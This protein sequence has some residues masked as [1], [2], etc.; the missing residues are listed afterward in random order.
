MY[1]AHCSC[2]LQGTKLA[3]D[4]AYPGTPLKHLATDNVY[5]GTSIKHLDKTTPTGTDS[6]SKGLYGL[7]YAVLQIGRTLVRLQ[8]V[9][10]EFFTDIILP[11]A[12]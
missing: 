2:C 10:L 3:T 4:N 9:S 6:F 11:I 12:L 5:P 7:Q 1:I 8:M